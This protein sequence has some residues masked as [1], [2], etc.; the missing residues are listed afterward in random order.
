LESFD[1]AF[2]AYREGAVFTAF[3]IETTGL[4]PRQDRIV[5]FGAVKFDRRGPICRYSALI[6][7]GV[8]MPEAAGRV[9]GI[10]DD[11]LA[12]KPPLERVFPDFLR[13]VHGTVIVAHNAPFDTG[14]VN[15]QLRIR[16][17]AWQKRSAAAAQ[18]SL[19]PGLE[20]GEEKPETVWPAPFPLLPNRI[21]D[22]LVLARRV[23]PQRSGY[24]L[25][26]LAA[27]LNFAVK[28]AH[29]AEDDARICMELFVHMAELVKGRA[30]V[31]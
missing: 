17:E 21:V 26:E 1:W 20:D 15:E 13:L 25:Q 28:N 4:D 27:A 9:N 5:E 14:F 22:T 24:K 6:N 8:P 12:D 30:N 10:T 18:G 29:R 31:V 7:P 23:F 19:L 3:D 16:Y 2:E 11:M